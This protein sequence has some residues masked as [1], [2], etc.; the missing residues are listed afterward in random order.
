MA[1]RTRQLECPRPIHLHRAGL[2]GLPLAVSGS[3]QPLRR[4]PSQGYG[5]RHR[6]HRLSP[7]G[8]HRHLHQSGDHPGLWAERHSRCR[9][10]PQY[11]S[12]K[13]KLPDAA[14]QPG[15]RLCAANVRPRRRAGDHRGRSQP[16][17][18]EGGHL[19]DHNYRRQARGH[20]LLRQQRLCPRR[21]NAILQLAISIAAAPTT[22][23][24]TRSAIRGAPWPN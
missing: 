9:G 8:R 20:G 6:I 24:W 1:D 17:R 11:R 16:N 15:A 12:A 18:G 21:A 10:L 13:G 5:E 4:Q 7:V 3:E 23:P 19:A 2:S 22:G 14:L